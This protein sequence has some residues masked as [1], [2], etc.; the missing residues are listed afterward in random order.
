MPSQGQISIGKQ[1][2]NEVR[3]AVTVAFHLDKR[4]LFFLKKLLFCQLITWHI[5]IINQELN[6][7]KS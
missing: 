7:V 5:S 3:V 2:R 1:E 6:T 4:I